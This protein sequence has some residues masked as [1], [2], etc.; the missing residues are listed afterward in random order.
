M[1]QI[2]ADLVKELRS[3]TGVG[4]MECKKA[5]SETSG[6]MDKAIEYLRKQGIAKAE[7]K[8][9]REAGEGLVEAYIHPGGRVGVLIEVNCETDF[10]A[11]TD[12]FQRL[13]RNLAM[14][15]AATRPLAV[16]RESVP[17]ELIE[18][19]RAIY[20]EIVKNEGKPEAMVPR[21]VEGKVDK[22]LQ[23]VVLMEQP[24]IRD[25]KKTVEEIVKE[26][27]AKIGEN[28]RV[29]RFATFTLGQD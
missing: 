20:T 6:N 8:A 18:R 23:S 16:T 4:M 21:I 7:T 11:R 3:R 12:E 10:V 2:T 24:Y 14:Q 5:L 19:E 15:V 9:G 26:A 1:T 13:V 17:A 28:I 27:I 25:D 22:F 29:R